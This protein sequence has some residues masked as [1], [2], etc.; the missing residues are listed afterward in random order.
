ME[1]DII[2]NYSEKDNQEESGKNGWV[3]ELARFLEIMLSQVL[4]RKPKITLKSEGSSLSAAELKNTH[5][6]VSVLSPH[7]INS[8]PCLEA[9]EEFSKKNISA[10][11]KRLFK[12]LKT[13][14]DYED[15][16]SGLKD[17]VPYN[18]FDLDYESG[19]SVI[20]DDYFG[21]AAENVYWM[22]MVDLA[23]DIH[24]SL[25]SLQA[26]IKKTGVKPL[27]KRDTIF[28]AETGQDLN[29]QRNVIRRE[30]QRNGYR[31]VPDHML[32]REVDS[33]EKIIN[34]ALDESIMSVHLIGNS[35][36]VI[37][38]GSD[39]SIVDIENRL[40]AQKV[41]DNPNNRKLQRLIWIAP[42]QEASNEQQKTFIENIQRDLS[43]L[44][45]A[46]IFQIPLEEFK[47]TLREE[48]FDKSADVDDFKEVISIDEKKLNAYLIYD[49]VDQDEAIIVS[50]ELIKVGVNVIRTNF[51][52]DVLTLRKLHNQKLK[53]FDI[54]IVFKGK[55][56]DNWVRMK[57]LDLLKAPG[58]GRR[59]PILGKAVIGGMGIEMNKEIYEEF[60]IEVLSVDKKEPLAKHLEKFI[61]SLNKAL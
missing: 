47:N 52:E 51:D 15:Q 55:V 34:E 36:G 25:L 8:N 35:Y 44:E 12:V 31:V 2:I 41:H 11:T 53:L 26:E 6:L 37:P 60:D 7:F 22:K 29:V 13:H 50:K 30:L 17:G 39:R 21:P 38:K 54:A 28:L 61:K 43:T 20:F 58:L 14:V 10:T 18:L 49:K 1:Q 3:T 27:Y 4:S 19:D 40:A 9:I 16:P 23:Y 48:L 46:E 56:N 57:L 42:D 59:K 24:E 45:A 33:A 5:I 32:P